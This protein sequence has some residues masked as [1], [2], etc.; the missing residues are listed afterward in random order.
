MYLNQSPFIA[1]RV[2]YLKHKANNPYP[3]EYETV[4]GVGILSR[5]HCGASQ[6]FFARL[7][8]EFSVR[9]DENRRE[10]ITW[11]ERPRPKA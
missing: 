7:V 11:K 4:N 2:S 6:W 8:D 3:A 5:I 10:F 9:V 1:E